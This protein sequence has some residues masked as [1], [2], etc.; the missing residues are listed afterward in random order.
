MKSLEPPDSLHLRA[1]QGWLELEIATHKF[2]PE[3]HEIYP[4]AYENCD[5]CSGSGKKIEV[6]NDD[7]EQIDC[8]RCG[9]TGRIKKP[10]V[11]RPSSPNSRPNPQPA[12]SK[13]ESMVHFEQELAKAHQLKRSLSQAISSSSLLS[14]DMIQ[15]SEKLINSID[16]LSKST[17][18][19]LEIL[20]RD[21]AKELP[22][23]D[24]LIVLLREFKISCF[25]AET[26]HSLVR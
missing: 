15:L 6:R 1:A 2:M 23:H 21:W 5:N 26:Y 25:A 20:Q 11:L 18:A 24:P 10:Q 22:R 14:R 9:G 4:E 8:P 19:S 3:L 16:P 17:E 7:T 12:R 13:E